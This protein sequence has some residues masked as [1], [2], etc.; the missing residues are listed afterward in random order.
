MKA[1][2]E[3]SGESIDES[4]ETESL[5]STSEEILFMPGMDKN[6][7]GPVSISLIYVHVLPDQK[8]KVWEIV[9]E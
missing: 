3:C 2:A 5:P 1:S 4:F 6:R 7:T 8:L 9:Q